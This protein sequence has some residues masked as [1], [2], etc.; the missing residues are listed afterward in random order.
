[1]PY[2]ENALPFAAG[3]PESFHAA[4]HAAAARETKTRTYLRYLAQSPATD[5]EAAAALGLPLSSINSIRNGVALLVEKTP[6]T[7]ESMYGHPCRVYALNRAGRAVV[8]VW[9]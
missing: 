9:K 3:S 5:H 6:E 8:E 2:T 7:R 1:M 4:Q